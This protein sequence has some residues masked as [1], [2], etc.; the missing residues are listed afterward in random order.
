MAKV[1]YKNVTFYHYIYSIQYFLV[2][3]VFSNIYNFIPIGED[4]PGVDCP[5]LLQM[6]PEIPDTQILINR[7]PPRVPDEMD[8]TDSFQDE[9]N[10]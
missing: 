2:F 1:V 8:M 4:A 5:S 7:T 10:S 6:K 9:N 3:I